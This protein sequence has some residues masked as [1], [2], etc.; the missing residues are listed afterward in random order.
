NS[1]KLMHNNFHF[2]D[3]KV[4]GESFP[5][6]YFTNEKTNMLEIP[7]SI[8]D[9]DL[10]FFARDYINQDNYEYSWML[11]GYHGDWVNLQRENKID[12]VNIP[13]GKYVLKVRYKNDVEEGSENFASLPIEFLPPWYLSTGA[14]LCYIIVILYAIVVIVVRS[15]RR[16]IK[17]HQ[18]I[19][20]EI[21]K[22]QRKDLLET[23]LNFFTNITHEFY[24]PLTLIKGVCEMLLE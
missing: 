12:L 3:I 4:G 18:Q 2:F 13:Y 22:N 6:S 16:L 8:P 11:E 19:L 20:E 5:L 21:E 24:T 7:D 10:T 14:I 1:N 15:R 9:F 23:K 17:K